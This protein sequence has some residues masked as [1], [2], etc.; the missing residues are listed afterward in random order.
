MPAWLKKFFKPVPFGLDFREKDKNIHYIRGSLKGDKGRIKI[1]YL[2]SS[3][4]RLKNN[5]YSPGKGIIFFL[6]GAGRSVKQWIDKNGLGTEY[7]E[8]LEKFPALHG[9]PI[10]AISFGMSFLIVND[11]PYPFEADLENIFINEIV[12]YFTDKLNRSGPVYL[13]GHSMGGF[14][15]ISLSLRHPEKF[16]MVLAVSPFLLPVSPFAAD[17]SKTI[18]ELEDKKIWAGAL[19]GML[20]Y[21]FKNDINWQ[22]YNPFNLVLNNPN[23][24]YPILFFTLAENDMAGF[25]QSIENFRELILKTSKFQS[26]FFKVAG[27]H[28]HPT[29]KPV[30]PAFLN[31][32]QATI[33]FNK[34][35]AN[36]YT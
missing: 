18:K 33:N 12:P 19:K 6:H 11:V 24:R 31:K 1:Q 3:K 23:S 30:F 20:T 15:A 28:Y 2:I 5:E 8:T 36:V 22:K 29:A 32:I 27:D 35:E 26:Y 13:I 21:L 7:F 10:V 16:P 34:E 14:N 4:N 25:H 9:L 17:L